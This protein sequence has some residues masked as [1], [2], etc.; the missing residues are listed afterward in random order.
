MI[1]EKSFTS[2]YSLLNSYSD[3]IEY[4]EKKNNYIPEFSILNKI[5]E[6]KIRNPKFTKH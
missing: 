5:K 4:G 2:Y 3:Y 1:D 6:I